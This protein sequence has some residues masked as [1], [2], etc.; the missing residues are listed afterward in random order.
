MGNEVYHIEAFPNAINHFPASLSLIIVC[1][2]QYHKLD[3]THLLFCQNLSIEE[4]Y[5]LFP[6]KL[7]MLDE[8]TRKRYMTDS[9]Y[10]WNFKE[11][12]GDG[13]IVILD[14]PDISMWSDKP[15]KEKTV[16]KLQEFWTRKAKQAF[17]IA[18]MQNKGKEAS[19]VPDSVKRV[20]KEKKKSILEWRK[21]LDDFVQE[22]KWI[23]HFLLQIED[24]LILTSFCQISTKEILSQKKFCF[25]QILP[26]Q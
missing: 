4:I 12:T 23:I 26:V 14:L 1:L 16:E 22:E 13:G 20:I 8:R 24:S 10:W 17:E 6:F 21:I 18:K 3:D 9:D 5:E 19:D 11:D 2:L 25:G 7:Q 15:Q